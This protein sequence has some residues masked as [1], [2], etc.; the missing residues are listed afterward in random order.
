MRGINQQG[1]TSR[2]LGYASLREVS[3][4]TVRQSFLECR[5]YIVVSIAKVVHILSIS[6]ESSIDRLAL[7][8]D[9]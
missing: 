9:T 7:R 2:S 3:D 4:K 6:H 8:L 5:R 1:M